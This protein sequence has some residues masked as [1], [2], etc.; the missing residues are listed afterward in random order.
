[1]TM[2]GRAAQFAPFAA[3]S[4]YEEAINETGRTTMPYIEQSTEL[5]QELSRRLSHAM[6]MP[7][8]P[9]LYITFFRPDPR[10]AGGDYVSV[11]SK[12]K[13]MDTFFNILVLSD[14]TEIPLDAICDI[15]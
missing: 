5:C 7:E 14:N 11:R 9:T 4:G 8:R 1:M 2:E 13:T 12:I 15:R 10:K 6:S 3:L